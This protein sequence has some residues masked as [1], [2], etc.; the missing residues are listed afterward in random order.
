MARFAD[1]YVI[2]LSDTYGLRNAHS[3][4]C[5]PLGLSKVVWH[6]T[7]EVSDSYAEVIGPD[8]I[9]IPTPDRHLTPI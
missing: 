2:Y 3:D 1:T 9:Q 5:V 4:T 6:P 7:M 8:G